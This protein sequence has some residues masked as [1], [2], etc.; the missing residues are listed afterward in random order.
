MLLVLLAFFI[1]GAATTESRTVL[2][3]ELLEGIT[4]G[5]I[6]T[7]DPARVDAGATVAEL[8][9]Q[10][11]RDRR[12]VPLVE[13]GGEIVGVVTLDDLQSVAQSDRVTTSVGSIARELPEIEASAD[14]FDTLA[15]LSGSGATPGLVTE[16][17]AVVGLLS[18]S[19]YAHAL[20][21]R[22]GFQSGVTG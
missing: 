21:I 18:D 8:G 9:N 3:D 13:D 6:M 16:N 22:R 17:G 4:V 19:D 10:L 1:Y 5:D 7:R 12:T 14:A 2:L 15:L 11:L 20:T